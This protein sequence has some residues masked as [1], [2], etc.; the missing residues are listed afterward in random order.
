MET[1]TAKK[2]VVIT[3]AAGGMGRAIC[4]ALVAAGHSVVLADRDRASV[5]AFAKELGPKAKEKSAADIRELC[6]GE[7]Q[8]WVGKQREQFQRLGVIAD[9]EHPYL[10]LQ[11]EYEA[12]EVRELADNAGRSGVA[13]QNAVGVG[14]GTVDA[15]Q[16]HAA[17]PDGGSP[18]PAV[19]ER[20]LRKFF[21]S[22]RFL[23][24]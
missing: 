20:S 12:E 11:P 16:R 19:A 10:T 13:A 21:L 5:E 24:H 22:H 17:Q 3:G 15:A 14:A 8:K 4:K 9:W 1:E 6:R 2:T 7:A 23:L 18:D